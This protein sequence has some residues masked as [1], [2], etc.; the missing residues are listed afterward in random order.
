M[1]V[2]TLAHPVALLRLAGVIEGISFLL[3]LFV[4]MPLKYLLDYP[5]AVRVVGSV[6]GLLFVGFGMALFRAHFE[7]SWPIARSAAVFG[8][9]LIPFGFLLIDRMLREEIAAEGQTDAARAA[10]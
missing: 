7:R 4:A 1:K 5:M 8:A 10:G 9:S 3:L 6:H 2:A